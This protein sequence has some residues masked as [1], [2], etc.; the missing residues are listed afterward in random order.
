M[1]VVRE[2]MSTATVLLLAHTAKNLQYFYVRRNAMI[3]KVKYYVV[4]VLVINCNLLNN[5]ITCSRKMYK[6][7]CV[8]IK[9]LQYR[10][11][12]VSS[13]IMNEINTK[14]RDTVLKCCVTEERILIGNY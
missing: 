9:Y 1:Q 14:C 8:M 2:K 3:L 6:H 11:S 7:K 13:V 5:K 10:V 12:D 4:Y